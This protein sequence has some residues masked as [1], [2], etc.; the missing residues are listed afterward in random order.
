[1]KS[2]A[3]LSAS[4][5]RSVTIGAEQGKAQ[6]PASRVVLQGEY[7]AQYEKL[8]ADITRAVGPAVIIEALWGRHVTDLV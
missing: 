6:L 5:M 7:A 4:S 3:V 1:M 8:H 2:S